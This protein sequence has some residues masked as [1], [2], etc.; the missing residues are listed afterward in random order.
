M[1]IYAEW[2]F[3]GKRRLRIRD[4]VISSSCEGMRDLLD[5]EVRDRFPLYDGATIRARITRVASVALAGSMLEPF[6][7]T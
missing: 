2:V 6:L 7:Q 4:C 3:G 5:S 1:K